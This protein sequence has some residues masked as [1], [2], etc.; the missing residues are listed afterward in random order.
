MNV[1]NLFISHSWSYSSQY[2]NFVALLQS[3]S[4]FAFKNYSVPRDDPIHTM[5]TTSQLRAAI[6]AQMASCHVVVV[7][8][9]VY[10][11]Y[12]WW[13]N[14]EMEIAKNGFYSPKP[15]LAVRP[16]GNVRTSEAVQTAADQIVGWNTESIV[17]A[18][19]DLA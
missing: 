8:A 10:S 19:R 3:R 18:I 13:I 12:S 16:W 17:Q 9:G 14:E 1:H 15:I 2:K 5:G 4:Y 6:K 11:T 7:M